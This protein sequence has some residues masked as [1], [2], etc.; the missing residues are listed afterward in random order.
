MRYSA[1]RYLLVF[2]L[3]AITTAQVGACAG[4]SSEKGGIPMTIEITSSAFKDGAPIPKKY[5]GSISPPLRWTGVPDG[6]K[7]LALICDDPDAPMG[8]W[9]HWVLY[10]LPP[11]LNELPEG[12]PAVETLEG[13]GDHGTNDF[14]GLG[15]GGPSPPPGKPHR[16]YF[17]LYALDI[18]LD[19]GPGARKKDVVKAMKGHILAQGELM[20]TYQR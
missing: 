9:V 2:W 13:G 20:G 10:A 5:S 1:V 7:S 19:L 8:T 18:E 6:T 11:D 17:K 4:D 3:V 15:Y 12:V 16:Y 14:K